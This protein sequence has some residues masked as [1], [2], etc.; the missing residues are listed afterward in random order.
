MMANL[1]KSN[2]F[3]RIGNSYGHFVDEHFMG[4]SP[5]EESW[6]TAPKANKKVDKSSYILEIELPGIEKEN[7]SVNIESDILRVEIIRASGESDQRKFIRKEFEYPSLE[8]FFLITKDVDKDAI[9]AKMSD[10]LLVI[11]LPIR[12]GFV[13]QIQEIPVQ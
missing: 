7:V 13:S 11:R 1:R 10:G 9:E 12:K 5:F 6:M 2:P 8:R 3:S 4:R